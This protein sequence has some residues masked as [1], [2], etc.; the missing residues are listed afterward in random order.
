MMETQPMAEQLIIRIGEEYE[1]CS[2]GSSGFSRG[3]IEELL[4]QVQRSGGEV[5]VL[6]PGEQVLLTSVTV[7]SRNQ[8]QILQAVPNLVEESLAM[9]I[10]ECHFALSGRSTGGD[11]AVAVVAKQTMHTWRAQLS[12]AGISAQMM[13]PDTLAAPWQSGTTITVDGERV[14]IRTGEFAGFTLAASQLDFAID[15]LVDVD[16]VALYASSAALETMQMSIAQ[17]EAI[18]GVTLNVHPTE[19]PLLTEYSKAASCNLLQGEFEVEQETSRGMQVWTSAAILAACTFLLHVSLL[20]GQGI[21]LE[22]SANRYE[23]EARSLY[24]EVF[25]N[26]RNVRDL[27]RRWR[28]HLGGGGATEGQFISLFRETAANLPGSN[29]TVNNINFN[30]SRGDLILQLHASRSEQLVLFSQT[31]N[32]IGLNAEIGTISQEED[33]VRGSIKVKSFGGDAS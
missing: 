17:I 27:R 31:L 12:D 10:D 19:Q 30:E 28:A 14:H 20:L 21:Y 5:V 25:P 13:L 29:L 15:L 26:D 16:E 33:S 9:D 8:R 22:I 7:P 23:Q 18:E 24:Q 2:P 4:D 11:I 6:V 1:W 32:K 3:T